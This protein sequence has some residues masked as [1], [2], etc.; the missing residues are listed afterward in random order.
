MAMRKVETITVPSHGSFDFKPG[1]YHVMFMGL[2]S[3]LKG[4]DTVTLILKDQN[5]Q[6]YPV[7]LVAKAP[8]ELPQQ[9]HHEHHHHHHHQE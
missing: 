3:T 1:G 9:D 5:N 4:G 7:S 8:G 2:T 6:T